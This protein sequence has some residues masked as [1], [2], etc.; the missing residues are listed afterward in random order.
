MSVTLTITIQGD[1][2]TLARLEKLSTQLNDMSK[3]FKT[4]GNLLTKFYSSVPFASRGSVYGRAWPGL[5]EAYA[6]RKAKLY[7]ARPVL[8]ASG[9]MAESFKFQSTKELLRIYNATGDLFKWH[10]LGEGNNPQRVMMLL[11]QQRKKVV[12][13]EVETHVKKLVENV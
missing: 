13:D 4:A 2:E 3:P 9:K 7:P 11:D 1:K 12:V 8:I 5:S 6:K 10:Q